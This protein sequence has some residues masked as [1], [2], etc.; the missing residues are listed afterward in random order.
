[1][2]ILL[3]R[4]I[5]ISSLIAV[6]LSFSSIYG[7]S[8]LAYADDNTAEKQTIDE[9]MQQYKVLDD[10]V[11]SINSEIAQ[12]DIDISNINSKINETKE[13]ITSTEN[14]ISTTE[15]S[16][17]QAEL[18]LKEK[19]E[20]LAKRLRAM[21]KSQMSSN[22]I[23]YI[24]ASDNLSDFFSRINAASKVINFDK[25]LISEINATKEQLTEDMNTLSE[26]KDSLTQLQ[27]Q[28]E[29]SL[30]ELNEKKSAK[31]S[32]VDELNSQMKSILAIVEE[33]E[34]KLIANSVS[35]IDNSNSI[36][37]L[38]NA[39]ATLTALIPQLN[40]QT[41]I[42][43]ANASISSG[44]SKIA[45]LKKKEEEE[46]AAAS[47]GDSTS[48]SSGLTVDLSS[49]Q[50][51]YTMQATAYTGGTFTATGSRPVRNPDGISTIAVD[52][53]VIPLGSKV[54]VDGYGVAI[55]ADTGGAIKG[56]IID[57]YFNS[58]AECISWGRR[59]VSVTI[60]AGPMEW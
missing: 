41:V 24:L 52:P 31:K 54:Y 28:N 7:T 9:N 19:E 37:D 1:M 57:L 43:K 10:E 20:S 55:A 48:T 59:D 11:M 36:S 14:E 39:I 16:L 58:E 60:L 32:K 47:R 33:N 30:N 25:N 21:Q 6:T 29:A 38:Q 44:E 35:T 40:S 56:N 5:I 45:D 17:E 46:K 27:A 4:S 34:T 15:A 23:S 18:E 13:Q 8:Y 51:T 22:L 26:K 42:D 12:F 53:S 50:A 3:K 2:S 49:G